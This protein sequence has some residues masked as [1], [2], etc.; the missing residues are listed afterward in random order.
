MIL[1]II[2]KKVINLIINIDRG[3]YKQLVHMTHCPQD[4]IPSAMPFIFKCQMSQIKKGITPATV[5]V[6]AKIYFY[7]SFNSFIMYV[8]SLKC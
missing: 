8:M 4:N 7:T 6:F 2:K 5:V 1:S 3:N